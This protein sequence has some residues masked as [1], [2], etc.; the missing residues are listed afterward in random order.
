MKL[1]PYREGSLFAV[2]LREGGYATGL[3]A[4][5]SPTGRVILAYLFG[6]KREVVPELAEVQHLQAGDALKALRTG[7]MAL[8]NGRWP[9]IGDA[10]DWQRGAWPVPLFIRRADALKRAWRATYSDE[11]PGKSV[12]E[13]S[14]PYETEGLEADSLY[15]YGSVELLLTK[16]LT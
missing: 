8:A 2:P 9:V 1:Q 16:L 7:D 3:V 12:R 5:M 14:V 13:E 11:D 10:H 15:G 4:R 6:P